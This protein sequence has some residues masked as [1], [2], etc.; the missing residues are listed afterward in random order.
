MIVLFAYDGSD[1]A[2]A[3]LTA[4]SALLTRDDLEV[5]VVTVWEPLV[6][7]ALQAAKFGGIPAVPLDSAP[8]DDRAEQLALRT[9]EHGTQLAEQLGLRARPVAIALPP[10]E[11]YAIAGAVI[12]TADQLDASLIVLGSRGL[13][14]VRAMLGSVS[15]HVAQHGHRPVLIIPAPVADDSDA[16]G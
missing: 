11:E 7:Q 13:A 4:A 3:A 8:I 5:V 15:N 12:E 10:A 1:G 14:G 16:T 9:A 6:V 2:D